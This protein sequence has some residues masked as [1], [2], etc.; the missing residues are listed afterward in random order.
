MILIYVCSVPDYDAPLS[1]EGDYTPKYET[2]MTLIEK[3]QVPALLRPPLPDESPSLKY[4]PLPLQEYLAYEDF[5][6]QIPPEAKFSS[7][8]TMSMEL[9]PMNGENGQSYGYVIYRTTKSLEN[10]DSNLTLSVEGEVKDFGILIVNGEN[11]KSET[12]WT[13]T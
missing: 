6:A 8:N 4:P 2:L 10:P 1:E 11:Q 3:Y 9:L 5:L 7:P 13:N 12:Y